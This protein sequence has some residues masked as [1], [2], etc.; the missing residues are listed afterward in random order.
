MPNLEIFACAHAEFDLGN[1]VG[2]ITPSEG[3]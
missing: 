3:N 1:V 2:M